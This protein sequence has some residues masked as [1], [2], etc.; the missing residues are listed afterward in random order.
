MANQLGSLI[1]AP[2]SYSRHQRKRKIARVGLG[3][4]QFSAFLAVQATRLSST[5]AVI[6]GKLQTYT[7][8]RI[9]QATNVSQIP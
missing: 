5:S 7:A 1:I 6:F 3:A 4:N 2:R 9:V 8:A